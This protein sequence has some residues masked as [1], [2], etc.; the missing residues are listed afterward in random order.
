M[1]EWV[2]AGRTGPNVS[3][4]QPRF[5]VGFCRVT[6]QLSSSSFGR[7]LGVT[8]SCDCD[9]IWRDYAQMSTN[10]RRLFWGR[11]RA[12]KFQGKRNAGIMTSKN[13]CKLSAVTPNR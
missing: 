3:P 13:E 8:L 11:G 1:L 9:R 12:E 6:L 10:E 5:N 2:S 7:S 4:H